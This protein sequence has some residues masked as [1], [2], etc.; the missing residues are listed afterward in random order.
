MWISMEFQRKMRLGW[1]SARPSKGLSKKDPISKLEVDKASY[2]LFVVDTATMMTRPTTTRIEPIYNRKAALVVGIFAVLLILPT[3]VTASST[4][5]SKPGWRLP[6]MRVGNKSTEMNNV[7]QS[8]E[9]ERKG[10]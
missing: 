6:K 3:I 10:T 5:S 1:L 9:I 7:T 8:S 2:M 4:P